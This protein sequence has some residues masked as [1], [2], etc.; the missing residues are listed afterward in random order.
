[1]HAR[2]LLHSGHKQDTVSHHIALN[3]VVAVS[4]VGAW[5]SVWDHFWVLRHDRH[6]V[7]YDVVFTAKFMSYVAVGYV[8]VTMDL[9]WQPF[10]SHLV[11]RSSIA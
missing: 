3:P 1:M 6:G 8:I 10:V 7:A 5:Q 2:V 9:W 4:T 11:F